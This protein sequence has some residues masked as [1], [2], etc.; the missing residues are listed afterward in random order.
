MRCSIDFNI[1]ASRSTSVDRR[2]ALRRHH[3][4]RP[5]PTRN[6]RGRP[7]APGPQRPAPKITDSAIAL[8]PSVPKH[9]TIRLR[10]LQVPHDTGFPPPAGS[11][12]VASD[13]TGRP[14]KTLQRH[15]RAQRT[16]A[17]DCAPSGSIRMSTTGSVPV[18]AEAA[19]SILRTR[20]A[21]A[22]A[23]SCATMPPRENPSKSTRSSLG[24]SRKASACA[25]I[26]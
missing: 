8:A 14:W 22:S 13:R 26:P 7:H 25:A 3:H 20:D 4:R 21:R 5:L 11:R 2:C 6:Q 24:A 19:N 12:F 15:H 10:C 1:T 23:I 9:R 17:D 16:P 18:S